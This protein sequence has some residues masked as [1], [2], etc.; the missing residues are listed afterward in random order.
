MHK[1]FYASGFIYSLP[2]QQILLQQAKDTPFWILFSDKNQKNE[3]PLDTFS[4]IIYQQLK[5]KIPTKAIYVIYEYSKEQDKNYHI[6]YARIDNKGKKLRAKSGYIIEWFTLKQLTKLKLSEQTKQ[7]IIVGQ[8]VINMI[9]R[10]KEE[11][12]TKTLVNKR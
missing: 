9:A 10:S 12:Q 11:S 4:R 5:I 1:D 3:K 8:R 6:F 7:N 2:T